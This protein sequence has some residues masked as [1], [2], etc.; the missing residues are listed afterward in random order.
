V[1][2]IEGEPVRLP[3]SGKAYKELFQMLREAL[4]APVADTDDDEESE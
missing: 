4:R 3:K 1:A 2:P